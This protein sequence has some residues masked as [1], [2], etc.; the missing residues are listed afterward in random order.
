MVFVLV[1]RDEYRNIICESNFQTN[2]LL[3][4]DGVPYTHPYAPIIDTPY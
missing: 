4:E 2:L 3:I 1:I